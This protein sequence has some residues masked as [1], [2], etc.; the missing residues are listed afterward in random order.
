M[1][2]ALVPERRGRGI[3]GALIR[4]VMTEAGRSGRFVSLHVE[5]ENPA[6]HLYVRLGFVDVEQVGV[7]LLMHWHALSGGDRC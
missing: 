2:I 7:Y 4:D 6:R 5:P 3:G 1:D